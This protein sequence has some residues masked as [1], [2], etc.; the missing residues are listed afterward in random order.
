M[1]LL[2]VRGPLFLQTPVS[3]FVLSIP[4]YHVDVVNVVLVL[5]LLTPWILPMLLL[6]GCCN[7]QLLLEKIL[8]AVVFTI[9]S[10]CW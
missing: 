6:C 2:V 4:I 5:T 10:C 3:A 7:P 9:K 8:A 1:Q